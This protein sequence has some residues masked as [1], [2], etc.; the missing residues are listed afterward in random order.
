VYRD[1]LRRWDVQGRQVIGVPYT[2]RQFEQCYE[3]SCRQPEVAQLWLAEVDGQIVAGKWIFY[4][5]Q[6]VISWEGANRSAFLGHQPSSVLHIEIMRDAVQRGY[7]Y[8]DFGPSG[9]VEGVIAFKDGHNA[10]RHPFTRTVYT[11]KE[12]FI[13]QRARARLRALRTSSSGTDQP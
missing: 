8:Y 7:A 10:E 13:V 5:N 2:W 1:A 9:G 4:W 3:L 11:A 12:S 6:H